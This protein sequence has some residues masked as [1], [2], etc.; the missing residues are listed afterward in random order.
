MFKFLKIIVK[1]ILQKPFFSHE[2]KPDHNKENSRQDLQH[3]STILKSKLVHST[4]APGRE[5]GPDSADGSH[6]VSWSSSLL[7]SIRALLRKSIPQCLIGSIH[8]YEA[9][10]NYHTIRGKARRN[11]RRQP[12]E[13]GFFHASPK[14][15]SRGL[16]R[17]RPRALGFGTPTAAPSDWRMNLKGSGIL[18]FFQGFS[19]VRAM[20]VFT[21]DDGRHCRYC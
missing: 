1:V 11:Q 2:T 16:R 21:C 13:R 9:H 14:R 17:G 12:V 6:G 20:V 18:I 4:L 8:I 7:G 10:Y 5:A 15:S 19:G 3:P